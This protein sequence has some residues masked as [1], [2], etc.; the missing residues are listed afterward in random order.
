MSSGSE[1]RPDLTKA[2][3]QALTNRRISLSS[4]RPAPLSAQSLLFHPSSLASLRTNPLLKTTPSTFSLQRM[5]LHSPPHSPWHPP[6]SYPDQ[7]RV[8]TST[9]RPLALPRFMMMTKSNPII[10]RCLVHFFESCTLTEQ[11][12]S[13]YPPELTRTP[14]PLSQISVG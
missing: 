12:H 4:C 11:C 7:A 13:F 8:R 10:S 9:P 5:T 1:R 14:I 6:K 3:A 2:T